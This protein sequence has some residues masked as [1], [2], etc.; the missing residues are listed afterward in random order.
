VHELSIAIS[1][2]E[3]SE[4]EVRKSNFERVEKIVL[5]IGNLAG[6]ALEALDFAWKEAVKNTVL[7]DAVLE[8]ELLPG[9]AKCLT[10]YYS[11]TITYIYDI[12]PACEDI[13]KEVMQGKELRIKSLTLI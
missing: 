3:T 4:E 12:C 11:F 10:C 9:K 1:I 8:I 2:V 5:E 6:V 7:Q 13:K